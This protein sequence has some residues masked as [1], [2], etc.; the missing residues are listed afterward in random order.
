[1]IKLKKEVKK[2]LLEG[3][4][5]SKHMLLLLIHLKQLISNQLQLPKVFCIMTE[6]KIAAE[7]KFKDQALELQEDRGVTNEQSRRLLE[8]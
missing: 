3:M 7:I 5:A 6:L 2:E 8:I 4:L 1:M